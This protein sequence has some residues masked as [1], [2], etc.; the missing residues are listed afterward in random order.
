MTENI[1]LASRVEEFFRH[2][3]VHGPVHYARSLSGG[4]SGAAVYLTAVGEL[5]P[6]VIKMGDVPAIEREY[7]GRQKNYNH[8]SELKSL[9]IDGLGPEFP[10]ARGQKW[11]SI[12]Y[13]HIGGKKY[14]HLK[15]FVDFE[16]YAREYTNG[17]V[18]TESI[19]E[20][21]DQLI[22][23]LR[24]DTQKSHQQRATPLPLADYLPTLPWTD[25]LSNGLGVA[26]GIL[27]DPP[28]LVDLETWFTTAS[29]VVTIAPVHDY[30]DLHGDPRF[31]NV[32]VDRLRSEAE[33]IDYGNPQSGHIFQDLARFEVDIWLRSAIDSSNSRRPIAKTTQL[34]RALEVVAPTAA[35]VPSVPLLSIWRQS[36][37]AN[38][39]EFTADGA[40][41]MYSWFLVCDLLKRLRW[42]RPGGTSEA[43]ADASEIIAM[44]LAIR[45]AIDGRSDPESEGISIARNARR[46]LGLVDLF[47]P[48]QGRERSV[49]QQRNEAK[50]RHLSTAVRGSAVRLL[51]ETGNSYLSTRGVFFD[52]I[53]SLLR[54]GARF[55]VVLAPFWP[56][57]SDSQLRT[58]TRKF[59]ESLD[60]VAYLR[61]EFGDQVEVKQIAEH[62]TA[63]VLLTRKHAFWEPY[64]SFAESRRD[65]VLLETFE[66]SMD[67]QNDP[68]IKHLLVSHWFDLWGRARKTNDPAE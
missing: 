24:T 43:G 11:R 17:D 19:R 42:V 27:G 26:S 33:L 15:N 56:G 32:L 59:D 18:R 58:T 20:C 10:G 37:L 5:P 60:G 66:L 23:R 41:A 62:L 49:N 63:T 2:H 64:I 57:Q 14:S 38:V 28:N 40:L 22:N 68:H 39:P 65:K 35:D 55:E 30:R 31:A 51:A 4:L 36:V 46:S 34:V 8:N 67:L 45:S 52:D 7:S 25:G 44:T 3:G 6:I 29:S 54:Q 1:D 50:R 21:I 13:L 9:G 16:E 48:V 53:V 47:V 61:Q 12:A